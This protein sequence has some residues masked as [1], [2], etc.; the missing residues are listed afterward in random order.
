M[1]NFRP[2]IPTTTQ[3]LHFL[4]LGVLEAVGKADQADLADKAEVKTGQPEAQ[5]KSLPNSNGRADY[6]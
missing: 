6:P 2:R 5:I 4:N 3:T 1:L